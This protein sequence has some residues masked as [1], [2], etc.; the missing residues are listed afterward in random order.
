MVDKNSLKY[1]KQLEKQ[2]N[3]R[4]YSEGVD[5]YFSD[6]AKMN[7]KELYQ[8][9][10]EYL[11]DNP[12]DFLHVGAHLFSRG[13]NLEE[14]SEKD[15]E[16]YILM[17]KGKYYEDLKDYEEA[18]KYYSEANRLFHE[19]HYFELKELEEDL[20]PGE[21]IGEQVTEKR[22]RICRKKLLKMKE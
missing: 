18:V 9:S 14:E 2:H 10:K 12:K 21:K 5:Y 1:L 4:L 7:G 11:K 8:R 17:G 19:V 20:P 16:I 6:E 13:F 15:K 3:D 22:L